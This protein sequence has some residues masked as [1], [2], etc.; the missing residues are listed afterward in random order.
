MTT[1]SPFDHPYDTPLTSGLRFLAELIGWTACSWATGQV[2]IWLGVLVLVVLIGLP[3]VFS[4]PGDKRYTVVP[5][6]GPLRIVLEL[7]LHFVAVVCAYL[8]WPA[9]FAF[10]STLI[11]VAAIVSVVPRLRWLLKGAPGMM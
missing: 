11:I 3:T 8:I 1:Q 9:W 10:F 5:T 6:P 4:T 7:L 2:S